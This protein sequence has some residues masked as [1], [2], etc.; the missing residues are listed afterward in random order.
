MD[1]RDFEKEFDFYSKKKIKAENG[2]TTTVYNRLFDIF[3]TT[4][5]LIIGT[6]VFVILFIFIEGLIAFFLNTVFHISI[7]ISAFFIIGFFDGIPV[8][9]GLQSLKKYREDQLK[10]IKE[11]LE[12]M[13]E[14]N[15]IKTRSL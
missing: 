5:G 11:I 9:F 14:T 7:G 8:Y 6:F 2:F 3:G 10:K 15:E 4:G 1:K 13:N 12:R